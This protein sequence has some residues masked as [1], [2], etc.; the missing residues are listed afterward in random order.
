MDR[1]FGAASVE[2][3]ELCQTATVKKEL[4]KVVDSPVCLCSRKDKVTD[5]SS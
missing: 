4:E 3:Q 2:M 5:T 1:R